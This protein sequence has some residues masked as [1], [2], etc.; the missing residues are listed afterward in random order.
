MTDDV[1]LLTRA[2]GVASIT[3]NRP[4]HGN[5]L[6]LEV[7]EG[8]AR[9]FQ[10][11]EADPACTVAVVHG[12]G[13]VFCGGGDLADLARAGDDPELKLRMVT[14]LQNTMF[15]IASSRLVVISAVNGAAAGAGLGLVLNT[16]VV[17]AS[18]RASFH[19]A[20][21]AIGLSPD[22]GVSSLLPRAIGAQRASAMMLTGA[23]LSAEDAV[24][25]GLVAQLHDDVDAAADE[26]A[27]QLAGGATQSLA[28]TKKLLNAPALEGYRAHLDRERQEISALSAHPDT[29]A[30]ILAL[31]TRSSSPE[32]AD[33]GRG[34]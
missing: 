30:R 25:W 8:L 21:A 18:S 1:V 9:A 27:L 15:A 13:R 24:G 19:G 6:S 12:T 2:A 29:R 16:D 5:A 7:M 26:L 11:A 17:L 3:L 33:R 32:P 23:R 22:A 34:T 31:V 14:T 10:D 20:Y 28:P 4:A